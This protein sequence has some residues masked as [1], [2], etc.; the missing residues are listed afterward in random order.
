M[1]LV[2]AAGDVEV[3]QVKRLAEKWFEPIGWC[4]TK[5]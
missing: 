1:R 4:K 3:D 5:T 2:V